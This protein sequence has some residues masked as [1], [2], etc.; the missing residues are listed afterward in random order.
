MR[1][2]MHCF[3]QIDFTNIYSMHYYYLPDWKLQT[4]ELPLVEQKQGVR[5]DG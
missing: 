1:I 4:L 2:W 3:I 5:H